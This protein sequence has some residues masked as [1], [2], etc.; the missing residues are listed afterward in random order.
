MAMDV[1]WFDRNI[2][3]RL[4]SFTYLRSVIQNNGQLYGDV[5]PRKK[6]VGRNGRVPQGFYVIPVYLIY[7]D[8]ECQYCGCFI[9]LGL[10]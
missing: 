10:V 7:G 2:T 5:A 6:Q 9:I 1:G 8:D 3:E 4:D